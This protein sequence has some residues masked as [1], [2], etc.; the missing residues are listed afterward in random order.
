MVFKSKRCH[1][2]KKGHPPMGWLHR[3]GCRA[4]NGRPTILWECLTCVK[5]YWGRTY[6]PERIT[7]GKQVSVKNVYQVDYGDLILERRIMDRSI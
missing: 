3:E 4:Q 6:S 2:I 1:Q 7:K 5:N